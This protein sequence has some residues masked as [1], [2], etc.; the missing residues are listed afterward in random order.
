MCVYR[1]VCNIE[2]PL[3]TVVKIAQLNKYLCPLPPIYTQHASHVINPPLPLHM[4]THSTSGLTNHWL[5]PCG[6]QDRP[7]REEICVA[8]GGLAAVCGWEATP[9]MSARGLP[10]SHWRWKWVYQLIIVV[11]IMLTLISEAMWRPLIL[12]YLRTWSNSTYIFLY[13]K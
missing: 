1:T 12:V 5:L 13:C 8:G 2:T 7:K 6:L 10:Q 11:I 4:H 9:Q 3:G